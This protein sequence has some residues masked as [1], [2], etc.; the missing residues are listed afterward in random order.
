MS[1]P[2]I[3][4]LFD[5][6][7]G[8]IFLIA[9]LSLGSQIHLLIGKDGLEPLATFLPRLVAQ[10]GTFLDFPSLF[11]FFPSDRAL[12]LGIAGGVICA[13]VIVIG[14][15]GPWTRPALAFATTIYLSFAVAGRT[16][17]SFQ[18]DN[19]LIEC[20]ALAVLLPRDRRSR[21]MHFIFRALLFKLYFESGLAKWQSSIRDWQDGSAMTYYY[22]T[23]PLPTWLAFYAHALPVWWHH[24]ESWL[25]LVLELAVPFA[26][27]GPRRARLTALVLL[28]VFQLADAAT[29]NYGFFCY[30]ALVLHLFLLDD[31]DLGSEPAP[32]KERIRIWEG[33]VAFLFV[34]VSLTEG[35][36]TFAGGAPWSDALL[37]ARVRY[38]PFRAV[39]TYHLFASITRQ[40]IEPIFEETSDGK[41]WI[42]LEM[43]HKAGAVDR[44]PDFVA[45]HQPRADFQLWFYGLSYRAR[46]P[47]YVE[48]LV[49]HLCQAP[50]IVQPLFRT[51]LSPRPRA[52]RIRFWQ[53][54]FAPPHSGAWWTRTA[55]DSSG[56]LD[57]DKSLAPAEN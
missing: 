33:A 54:H 38:L 22:E 14:P 23:A 13:L 43:Q 17:F 6:L 48:S 26:I 18:W 27:F 16:F 55:V 52:V 5:R 12:T 15:R 3:A 37:S 10:G 24:L 46:T 1:G 7:L 36:M 39:N 44:R 19:L 51:S 2:K 4:R 34:F 8:G 50:A 29:A 30:L 47:A 45:P 20:G 53:Y 35:M 42:E 11:Y 31:G 49:E 25:T 9:F 40:R 41:N 21:L 57:C 28:T 32:E 56:T